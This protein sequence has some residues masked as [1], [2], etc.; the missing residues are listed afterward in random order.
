[1]DFGSWRRRAAPAFGWEMW[2]A[3]WAPPADGKT[4]RLTL[5]PIVVKRRIIRQI[6]GRLSP[7]R[8]GKIAFAL[9]AVWNGIRYNT[10]VGGLRVVLD[11]NVIVAAVRSRRGASFRVISE[12]GRGRFE[13]VLS[14]PLLVEYEDALSRARPPELSPADVSVLIDYL[15]SQAHL[16]E[17]Y[18][19]WRPHLP[20]PKDDM[21]L[22]A[23]AA[24]HCAAIVTHNGRHFEPAS[25]F[26]IR[27]LSP[28]E[29]LRRLEARP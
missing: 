7:G 27:I 29:F 22:E 11:T 28:F 13:F 1:M 25:R 21:V 6:V 10:M 3:A 26:G 17:I 15:C 18:Y 14:V 24:G 8:L 2:T 4:A 16:Q 9:I 23:A 5:L 12:V 20:D 19:L